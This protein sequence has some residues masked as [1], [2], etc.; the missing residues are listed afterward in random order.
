MKRALKLT[1]TN[2]E[3][4]HYL[5][6]LGQRMDAPEIELDALTRLD[7][8]D[9][10]E[11]QYLPNYAKLLVDTERFDRAIDIIDRLLGR[12]PAMKV[13]QK[14]KLGNEAKGLREYCQWRLE[15]RQMATSLA[16]EVKSPPPRRAKAGTGPKPS[17]VKA[18]EAPRRDAPPE[19]S[20]PEIPVNVVIDHDSFQKPLSAGRAVIGLQY[21]VALEAQRIRFGESFETLIC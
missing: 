6:D 11:D 2:K 13:P 17:V 1:P 20:L 15:N 21:E 14:R 4:L 19:P 12:L 8:H 9:L 10:L 18:S 3:Y 16:R 7:K 5:G